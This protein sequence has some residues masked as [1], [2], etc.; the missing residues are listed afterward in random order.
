[1]SREAVDRSAPGGIPDGLDN[2]WGG[3]AARVGHRL[4]LHDRLAAGRIHVEVDNMGMTSTPL[5][6]C[7]VP[8]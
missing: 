7:I 4:H 6:A 3:P 2:K 1:M 8:R 5:V